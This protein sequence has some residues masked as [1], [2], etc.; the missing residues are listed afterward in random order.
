MSTCL[1][2]INWRLNVAPAWA[3]RLG[4]GAC[5]MKNTKAVTLNHWAACD[6]WR[7]ASADLVQDRAQW[8]TARGVK[9]KT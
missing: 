8:L 1:N 7:S 3:A 4:M 6:S 9:V 5:A 2:C